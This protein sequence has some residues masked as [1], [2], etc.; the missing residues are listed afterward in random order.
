MGRQRVNPFDPGSAERVLFDR[1][2]KSDAAA[3]KAERERDLADDKRSAAR[4]G[5]KPDRDY[6]NRLDDDLDEL[7]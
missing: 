3:R 1:Y 4:S 6:E 7:G 5:G 2:R